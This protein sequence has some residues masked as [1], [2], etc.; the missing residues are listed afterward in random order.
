MSQL[1]PEAAYSANIAT[2]VGIQK[3][4]QEKYDAILTTL[5]SAFLALSMSFVT[6]PVLLQGGRQF[7]LLYF[8]WLG[9]GVTIISTVL[10]LGIGPKAVEWHASRLTPD[11][12]PNQGLANCN[13][14]NQAIK[15]MNMASGISFV[16]AIVL[17]IVFVGINIENWRD[18]MGKP[19]S[20]Q[21]NVQ[22]KGLS[23]PPMQT[24]EPASSPASGSVPTP[25]PS[26]TQQ[27]STGTK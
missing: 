21:E 7:W 17:T 15:V 5:G 23:I 8:S 11:Q 2:L 4:A 3:S 22:Q 9:F 10:S 20:Q 27:G 14:W 12:F 6:D 24:Q 26:P 16:T 13:P 1:T 18:A 19:M 25:A